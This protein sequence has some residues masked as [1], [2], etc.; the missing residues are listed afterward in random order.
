MIY[1]IMLSIVLG[2][3]MAATVA[4]ATNQTSETWKCKYKGTE[5]FI[6]HKEPDV[7]EGEITWTGSEGSWDIHIKG[8]RSEVIGH[9]AADSCTFE[10]TVKSGSDAGSTSY[11]DGTRT[12][13]DGNTDTFKGTWGHSSDERTKG[14]TWEGTSTC[15]GP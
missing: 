15:T 1:K 6:G 2:V 4:F 9:C 3:T 8:G 5:S 13:V 7:I 10:E 12:T 11:W 14:G